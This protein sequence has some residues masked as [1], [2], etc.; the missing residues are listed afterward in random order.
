[1]K[2]ISCVMYVTPPQSVGGLQYI[3]LH[4]FILF[5]KEKERGRMAPAIAWWGRP[6]GVL[7][8]IPLHGYRLDRAEHWQAGSGR[9]LTCAPLHGGPGQ[10]RLCIATHLDQPIQRKCLHRIP[11]P[12]QPGILC[13]LRG[14][15]GNGKRIGADWRAAALLLHA[16][17]TV[18]DT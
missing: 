3:V 11:G 9:A 2:S 5:Q 4:M 7:A 18:R 10:A 1:M 12:Y 13:W 17:Y 16:I 8:C 6:V 15:Q 14:K